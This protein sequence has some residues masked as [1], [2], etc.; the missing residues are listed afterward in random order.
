MLAEVGELVSGAFGATAALDKPAA[1]GVGVVAEVLT[2]AECLRTVAE[3]APL[4]E[5]R[6]GDAEE[7]GDLA[8]A[9]EPFAAGR[10]HGRGDGGCDLAGHGHSWDYRAGT[11]SAA[12][13][14][15]EVRPPRM[16]VS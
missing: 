13:A 5:G 16:T 7:V 3:V 12:V 10:I 9:P 15:A 6:D 11:S 4:V 1:D 14:A 8:D 2:D